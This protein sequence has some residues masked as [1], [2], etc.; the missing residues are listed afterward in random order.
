MYKVSLKYLKSIQKT[1]L[2]SHFCRNSFYQSFTKVDLET[3]LDTAEA[4][5]ELFQIPTWRAPVTISQMPHW[6]GT[7]N[8]PVS[9]WSVV[10]SHAVTASKEMP[11]QGAPGPLR[12]LAM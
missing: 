2:C 1:V 11:G 10:S 9:N 4:I 8:Y 7:V 12:D 6:E 5:A 3:G